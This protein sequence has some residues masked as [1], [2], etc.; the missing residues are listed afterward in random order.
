LVVFWTNAKLQAG[1][2]DHGEFFKK[3]WWFAGSIGYY[4]WRRS[5]M[6]KSSEPFAMSGHLRAS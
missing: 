4:E 6:L 3:P 5:A 1:Q 2:K